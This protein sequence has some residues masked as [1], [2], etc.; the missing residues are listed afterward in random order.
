[1][2]VFQR[3]M[4]WKCSTCQSKNL[5]RYK[6]CQHCGDPKQEDEKFESVA[7][8][9]AV[10]D[11]DLIKHAVAGHDWHCAYCGGSQR[12]L[13]GK[14]QN[15]S[16]AQEDSEPTSS[17]KRE[18]STSTQT[19]YSYPASAP[20]S[21]NQEAVD[22]YS[23]SWETHTREVRQ[24]RGRFS[25][26][27]SLIAL[28]TLVI[29]TGGAWF[30]F[31]TTEK[32]VTVASVEWRHV[33]AVERY[34][35]IPDSGFDENI[36][37]DAFNRQSE[38]RRVHHHDRV[39]CGTTEE[40]YTER[41][42]DGES[43]YTTPVRCSSND[44]GFE[45][46]SGGDRECSPKYRNVTK[47]RTVTKYC[48]EP[49]YETWYSWNVWRWRHQRYVEESGSSVDTKWPSEE[50]INLQQGPLAESDQ[51]NTALAVGEKE[52]I[53]SRTATYNVVF[54]DGKG[55]TYDYKPQGLADFQNKSVG[56]RHKAKYSII[57]GI[58]FP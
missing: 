8:G 32:I 19:T 58:H 44:N 9:A 47:Y 48:D 28:A 36:P 53:G 33:V 27:K 55:K 3:E 10:T 6:H 39:S 22:S 46:C 49:R 35:I 45:T 16:G 1:M 2:P 18:S 5:G 21:A 4:K 13:D 14:C 29:L 37:N 38:G 12:R 40:S 17:K 43:C 51:Q 24:G 50:K 25:N 54:V 31:R 34:K 15:C 56:S 7:D 23:N 42:Q 41:E 26:N 11:P 57:R 52:R 30:L 20:T